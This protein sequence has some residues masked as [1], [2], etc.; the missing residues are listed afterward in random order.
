ML[1]FRDRARRDAMC[2]RIMPLLAQDAT[3]DRVPGI[4]TPRLE[5]DFL[6]LPALS[7]FGSRTVTQRWENGELT[8]FQYLMS[9]N[10]I[11]GRTYNDLNQYPVFPW[12]LADYESPVL[13]LDD[14]RTYRD[15]SK[16]MGA[17]TRTR[18][19]A[20]AQRFESWEVIANFMRV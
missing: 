17:Q 3:P 8:N 7:V 20:F 19:D 4:D 16:P 10:T 18:A 13:D 15:L 5:R 11:A 14:S 6:G 2:D 12:I 9:L 1:V